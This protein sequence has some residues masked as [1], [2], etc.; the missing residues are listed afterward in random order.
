MKALILTILWI[1]FMIF[2][3]TFLY[4]FQAEPI[5]AILL[6]VLTAIPLILSYLIHKENI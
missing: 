3:G 2:F 5:V 1:T 6:S 4:T